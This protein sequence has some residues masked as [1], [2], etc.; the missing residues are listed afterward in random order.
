M[1]LL[2]GSTFRMGLWN[3]FDFAR[4]V[5]VEKA[6]QYV[7]EHLPRRV[8][9]SPPCTPF[10]I[11]QAVN[12]KTPAQRA[13]L[14]KKIAWGTKVI[15]NMIEVGR[16]AM[17]LG[18]ELSYEHPANASSWKSIESLKELRKQLYE[19]SVAGCAWGMVDPET[20]QAVYKNWRFLVS[21]IAASEAID[22]KCPR[23]HAHRQLEG[24]TRVGESAKYPQPLCEA[25]SREVLASALIAGVVAEQPHYSEA[26]DELR[27]QASYH[28]AFTLEANIEEPRPR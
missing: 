17:S 12:Q 4:K 26:L 1:E 23:N 11:L 13:N 19:V 18:S 9:L 28:E 5:T 22:R 15:N 24:H 3:K 8:H 7:K 21:S 27:A 2:G 20:G 6:K 10:S 14:Q 25:V 16:Y